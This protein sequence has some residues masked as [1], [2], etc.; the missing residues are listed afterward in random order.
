MAAVSPADVNYGETLST[1]RYASRAKNIVNS[2]TVNEDSGVKVIRELQAEV[3]RLRWL[4]EEANQVLY[5]FNLAKKT[6]RIQY[7]FLLSLIQRLHCLFTITVGFQWGAIF[8]CEGGGGAASESDT[9]E[10]FL[11]K[12]TFDLFLCKQYTCYSRP[13]R[14]GPSTDQGVD[15]QMGRDAEYFAGTAMII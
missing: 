1:L 11:T 12:W 9:G 3:T 8:L 15:Q 7:V 5:M 14:P 6:S 4:L 2:P 13:P 10:S